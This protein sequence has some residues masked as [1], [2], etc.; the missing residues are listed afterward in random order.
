[1][2][3]NVGMRR[4]KRRR[5]E[6]RQEIICEKEKDRIQEEGQLMKDRDKKRRTK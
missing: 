6:K 3:T 5:R 1:M 2:E 4:G